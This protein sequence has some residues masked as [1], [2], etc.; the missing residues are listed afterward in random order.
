MK[1]ECGSAPGGNSTGLG[2]E[3]RHQGSSAPPTQ[4][5]GRG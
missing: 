4:P 3:G 2:R 1:S 5:W